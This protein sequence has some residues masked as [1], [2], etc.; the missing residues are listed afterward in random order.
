MEQKMQFIYIVNIGKI[1]V[2]PREISLKD[3]KESDDFKTYV[4]AYHNSIREKSKNSLLDS[5]IFENTKH[6]G[7]MSIPGTKKQK[8]LYIE[9]LLKNYELPLEEIFENLIKKSTT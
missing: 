8:S 6:D 1:V 3:I 9:Y 2:L 5:L 4:E 7:I